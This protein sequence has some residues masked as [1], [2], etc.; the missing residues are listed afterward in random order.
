[1]TSSIGLARNCINVKHSPKIQ[2]RTYSIGKTRVANPIRFYDPDGM[3]GW[4]ANFS[5]Y[6]I[7]L[8]N[9]NWKTVE[10]Y[11]QAKKFAGTSLEIEIANAETPTKA[12]Q[13]AK[14]ASRLKRPDWEGV[15][16]SIMYQALKAKFSQHHD[17]RK[18]L[19][20]T[21]NV[22]LIEDSEEDD[23]WGQN[24]R[25]QGDNVMGRLLMRVREELADNAKPAP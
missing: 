15:R 21:G 11:F 2:N 18:L 20:S 22:T 10:H 6:S 16:I 7:L 9:R 14:Q 4:L 3:W 5:R 8:E 23:F 24:R 19:L 17:L 25:G 1:L 13:L 12:K